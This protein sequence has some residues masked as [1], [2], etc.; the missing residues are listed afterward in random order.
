MAPPAGVRAR[1]RCRL[2]EE[3]VERFRD[4]FD[5]P[6]ELVV[7]GRQDR[8]SCHKV[9]NGRRNVVETERKR[10]RGAPYV[11]FRREGSSSGKPRHV[12]GVGKGKA[13]LVLPRLLGSEGDTELAPKPLVV[14]ADGGERL[15][16]GVSPHQL[17]SHRDDEV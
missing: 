6:H 3:V 12:A 7:R 8:A 17:S 14:E 4:V 9:A 5:H 2:Y 15:D 13:A 10:C 1:G 11:V 16:G